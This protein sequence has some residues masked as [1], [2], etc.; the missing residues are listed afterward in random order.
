MFPEYVKLIFGI[1]VRKARLE[2]NLTATD[3]AQLANI[4]PSYLTEIEKGRKHPKADKIMQIAN[5][6]GKEYDELVS[7]KLGPELLH[8]E[9]LLSSP[10]IQQFP[11]DL[12]GLERGDVIELFSKTP[13]E[14]SAVIHAIGELARFADLEEEHLFRAILRSYQEI[15]QNYFL[16]VEKA[17][18]EFMEHHAIGADEPVSFKQL[19][20][21]LTR[22][23]QYILDDTKLHSDADLSHY[24]SIL[25]QGKPHHLLIN[26]NL[27]QNQIKFLLARELGY[28]YL[29]LEERS[30]TSSPDELNSFEQ[31]LNDFKAS[32]FGGALLMPESEVVADLGSF[33]SNPKFQPDL[34]NQMLTTYDITPEM[35]FYRFSELIPKFFDI[36]VH[37]LRTHWDGAKYSLY[38]YLN[39]TNLAIPTGLR[40]REQY[41]RRWLSIGVLDVVRESQDKDVLHIDVQVS[42]SFKSNDEYLC[43]GFGRKL[44]LDSQIHSSVIIGMRIDN[45]L[46]NTIH[47]LEDER[48][49][50]TVLINETCERCSFSEDECSLRAAPPLRWNQEKTHDV[51]WQKI[52]ILNE[53]ISNKNATRQ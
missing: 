1:K 11:F 20:S 8:L 6:L 44:K 42:K 36:P 35:L 15:H 43:I 3:F 30:V 22:E 40:M 45:N 47:F 5:A 7:I 41:C 23:Y 31:V 12:L 16:E 10:I 33:F 51:R 14:A 21:I 13:K 25:V 37:F 52:K 32:Y 19:E 50:N 28:Q 27:D 48:V 17:A 29:A 38:K 24:R 2:K 34:L 46:K 4:S 49:S 26:R 9:K 39:M 18:Q 53:E